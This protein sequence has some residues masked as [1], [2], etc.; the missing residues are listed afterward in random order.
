MYIYLWFRR[1]VLD[2]EDGGLYLYQ[3]DRQQW[4]P[5]PPCWD[6]Q[7]TCPIGS[8]NM[9]SMLLVP[10]AVGS[11]GRGELPAKYSWCNTWCN[12]WFPD[13]YMSSKP[14]VVHS[15]AL[16]VI[17]MRITCHKCHS[18]HVEIQINIR[19]YPLF[20][21]GHQIGNIVYCIFDHTNSS[22]WDSGQHTS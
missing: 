1:E 6:G 16:Y 21:S 11:G 2:T 4:C 13:A 10:G 5:G 3:M 15:E 19:F 14:R 18:A 12:L 20:T 22:F 8:M 7:R 17:T 9:S